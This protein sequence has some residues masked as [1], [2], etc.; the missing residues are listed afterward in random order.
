MLNRGEVVAT[1]SPQQVLTSGV[2]EQIYQV[3]VEFIRYQPGEKQ[4][5][6]IPGGEQ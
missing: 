2:V 1:G 5:I 6:A 4:G 3:P